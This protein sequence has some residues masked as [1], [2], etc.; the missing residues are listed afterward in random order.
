MRKC[1]LGGEEL[2]LY[3]NTEET[4]PEVGAAML[5]V[6]SIEVVAKLGDIRL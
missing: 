6:Y 2:G 3:K 5:K 1:L 4:D